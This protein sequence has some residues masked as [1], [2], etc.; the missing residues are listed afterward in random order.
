MSS[1]VNIVEKM[2][3]VDLPSTWNG[4][5]EFYKNI[6]SRVV[7]KRKPSKLTYLKNEEILTAPKPFVFRA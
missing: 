2:P 7:F 5:D 4:L 1:N 3:I 6:S